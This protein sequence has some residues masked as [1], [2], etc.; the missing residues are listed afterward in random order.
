MWKPYVRVIA[1][2]AGHAL[3]ILA[4]FHLMAQLSKAIDEVWAQETQE[5]KAKGDDPLLTK[6]R[7]RLRK[8]PETLTDT[9]GSKRSELLQYNLTSIRSYL[10]KEAFQLFWADVSPSWAC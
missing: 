4:R 6:T 9:Q 8:R 1:K 10:L 5:L 3:P 2:K 7:G